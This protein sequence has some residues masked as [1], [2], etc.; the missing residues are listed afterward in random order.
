MDANASA[1]GSDQ[2]DSCGSGRD[3]VGESMANSVDAGLA[4]DER[5]GD[6]HGASKKSNTDDEIELPSY[7]LRESFAAFDSGDLVDQLN[8]KKKAAERAGDRAAAGN[9]DSDDDGMSRP[10]LASNKH[11]A[12]SLD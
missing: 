12:M 3:V 8:L 9:S 10:Y 1:N 6:S 2:T 11:L 7:R 4:A 5:L